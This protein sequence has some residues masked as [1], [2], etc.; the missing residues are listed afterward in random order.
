[1]GKRNECQENAYFSS[2]SELINALCNT[3]E[4]KIIMVRVV[5]SLL[6]ARTC[7]FSRKLWKA[8]NKPSSSFSSKSCSDLMQSWANRKFFMLFCRVSFPVQHPKLVP[9]GVTGAPGKG[10]GGEWTVKSKERTTTAP[11]YTD[12]NHRRHAA[13]VPVWTPQMM[14]NCYHIFP[15]PRCLSPASY[16][17]ADACLSSSGVFRDIN[18]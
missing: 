7:V 2:H 4:F 9:P 8:L 12:I 5:I 13:R 1:M 6:I 18:R 17:S 3:Q 14:V 16:T 11:A 10:R 15:I